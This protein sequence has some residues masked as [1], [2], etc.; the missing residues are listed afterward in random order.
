MLT[1]YH[2]TDHVTQAPSVGHLVSRLQPLPLEDPF[3]SFAATDTRSAIQFTSQRAPR[4]IFWVRQ[5]S[6]PH[7]FRHKTIS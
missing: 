3:S 2:V 5:I 1:V 7:I 4:Q 6:C